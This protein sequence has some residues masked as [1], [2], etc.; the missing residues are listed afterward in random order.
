[1]HN[2][3]DIALHSDNGEHINEIHI[4]VSIVPPNSYVLSLRS[5]A[6]YLEGT[7]AHLSPSIVHQAS[8]APVHNIFAELPYKKASNIKV[9]FLD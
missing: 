5:I 8:S 9:G 1:M 2:G 7:L 4:S 3:K 6:D